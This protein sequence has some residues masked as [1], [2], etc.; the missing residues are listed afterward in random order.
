MLKEFNEFTGFP[1]VYDRRLMSEIA[2][3]KRLL[4]AAYD[5]LWEQ[6]RIEERIWGTMPQPSA[7]K[8]FQDAQVRTAEAL[9]RFAEADLQY[10]R[11]LAG[12]SSG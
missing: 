6:R 10:K 1:R 3:L 5:N 9:K 7:I 8:E 4:D 12:E 2:R 11:A